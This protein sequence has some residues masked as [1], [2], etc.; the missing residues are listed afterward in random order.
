MPDVTVVVPV[1]DEYVVDYLEETLHSLGAQVPR[2][3]IILVDNASHEPLP[4]MSDV[5]IVRT[6]RRVSVGAARSH[7]LAHV[8][9]EFVLFWDA[10]D[11]M[12]PGTIARLRDRMSR[13]RQLTLLA[14]KIVDDDLVPH[15]WPRTFTS[16]LARHRRL[17]AFVHCVSSL[18][19]TIGAMMRTDTA[20]DAGGFADLETGDDWVLGVSLAFRG[21][22]DVVDHVGRI[23]RQHGDS[24][25]SRRQTA[26]HLFTHARAVRERIAADARAPT[27]IRLLLPLIAAGQWLV[28]RVVR[29]IARARRP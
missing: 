4:V 25:W 5:E 23:Y 13:E 16:R 24:V 8:R 1:W 26:T 2:P 29:P 10:D 22:V 12:P 28:I 20:R 21:R 7:G 9:S 19:P 27:S 3:R 15:H 6:A 14:T 17:F 18:V 11:V